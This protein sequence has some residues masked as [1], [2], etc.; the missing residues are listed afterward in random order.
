MEENDNSSSKN[1][2]T[3][4]AEKIIF[5]IMV[6]Q[7]GKKNAKETINKEYESIKDNIEGIV[8]IIKSTLDCTRLCSDKYTYKSRSGK[9]NM[10]TEAGNAYRNADVR[11]SQTNTL[12][13]KIFHKFKQAVN[14]LAP[15]AFATLGVGATAVGGLATVMTGGATT[16]LLFAS[17][18]VLGTMSSLLFGA[19]TTKHHGVSD[20]NYYKQKVDEIMNDNAKDK[21]VD[22]LKE[23]VVTLTKALVKLQSGLVSLNDEDVGKYCRKL[24]DLVKCIQK[25]EEE[26]KTKNNDE[27]ESNVNISSQNSLYGNNPENISN[28]VITK[29]NLEKAQ[30]KSNEQIDKITSN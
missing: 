11:P 22:K 20:A 5:N 4:S 29:N 6:H 2:D 25:K 23:N 10:L 19:G 3:Q 21:G 8:K 9:K 27:K 15:V 14:Y 16:P 24:K 30:N 12:S 7:A 18:G 17:A 13:G 1:A 28:D 26:Q